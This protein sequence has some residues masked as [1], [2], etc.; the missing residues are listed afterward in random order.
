MG[1]RGRAQE[2]RRCA[3]EAREDR[4]LARMVSDGRGCDEVIH[5]I[6]AVKAA[7]NRWSSWKI[8]SKAAYRTAPHNPV[9]SKS[10]KR[11]SRS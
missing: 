4:G 5:Q 7:L 2:D 11:P 8:I 3:R 10:S 6:S 1:G 9:K